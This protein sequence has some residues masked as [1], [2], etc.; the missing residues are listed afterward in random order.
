MAHAAEK[1]AAYGRFSRPSSANEAAA[2]EAEKST[3]AEA[4]AA[5]TSGCTPSSAAGGVKGGSGGGVTAAGVHR[6]W[7][8]MCSQ[9][10]HSPSITGPTTIPPPMPSM[11]AQGVDRTSC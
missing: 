4:V 8:A 3:I 1:A 10:G 6:T 7:S 2:E 11:P 9:S 5:D